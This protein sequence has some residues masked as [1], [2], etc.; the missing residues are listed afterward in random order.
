[1]NPS[2]QIIGKQM[3]ATL[4]AL[5]KQIDKTLIEKYINLL[6]EFQLLSNFFNNPKVIIAGGEGTIMK[7]LENLLSIKLMFKNAIM[8]NNL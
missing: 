7:F 3:I 4:K 5:K 2:L 1:M 8:E 6:T